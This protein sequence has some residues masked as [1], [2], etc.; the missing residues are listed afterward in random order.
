MDTLLVELSY[1]DMTN[2]LKDGGSKRWK[3]WTIFREFD[4]LEAEDTIIATKYRT[5]FVYQ[6]HSRRIIVFP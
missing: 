4:V 3:E 2:F 6:G 5:N 1:W